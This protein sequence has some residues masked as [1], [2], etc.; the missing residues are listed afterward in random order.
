MNPHKFTPGPLEV[1]KHATPEHSPQF[2]I[3]AGDSHRDH[4]IVRGE[5]AEADATL[6]AAAPDLLAALAQIE[7][8]A[9]GLIDQSATHDGLR[10]CDAL[11]NARSAI[12][13]AT[14]GAW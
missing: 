2:G 5:N 9:S 12:A 8:L 4:V 3:H 6:Y 1:S 14:G 13:K 11:A 7:R 10:N